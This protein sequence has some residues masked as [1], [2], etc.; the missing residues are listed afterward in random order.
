MLLT[1]LNKSWKNQS[2]KKQLYGHLLS[3]KYDDKDLLATVG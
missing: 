1:V 3:H 2:T